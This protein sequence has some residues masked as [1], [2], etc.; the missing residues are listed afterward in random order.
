VMPGLIVLLDDELQQMQ[1]AAADPSIPS[2]SKAILTNA[3]AA[4]QQI[5]SLVNQLWPPAP[6]G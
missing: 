5:E 1:A 3:I 6:A 2:D 4:D